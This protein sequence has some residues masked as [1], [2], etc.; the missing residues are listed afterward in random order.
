MAHEAARLA[1]VPQ[2][3]Y[4]VCGDRDLRVG[5][6]I[7]WTLGAR[8]LV[9]YRSASGRVVAMDARCPHLG[10][11]L[12]RGA[13]EGEHLRCALH[14]WTCDPAGA[15]RPPSGRGAIPQT[16]YPTAERYGS[17]FVFAGSQPRFD[18]PRL[19]DADPGAPPLRVLAGRPVLVQ[20][21]W[22]SLAM[23]A[24]DIAHMDAIHH[25]VLRE[26]PAISLIGGD[27]LELQY[28]SRITGRGIADRVVR[29]L[30]NDR[31]RATIECWG[32][33]LIVVRSRVGRIESRLLLCLTPAGGNVVVVPIVGRRSGSALADAIAL[34]IGRWLFTS[35]LARDVVPLAGMDLRI[36]RALALDGPSGWAARWLVT[37]PAFE[38]P[39][40]R[41]RASVQRSVT[42]GVSF[43]H[44]EPGRSPARQ[45][46]DAN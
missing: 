22:A 41:A 2:S 45:V 25:R 8:G 39:D 43:P 14:H 40:N 23:N 32:G 18:V 30:A 5:R 28:V 17:I 35:F 37:L 27:C 24:F 26:E 36:D 42:A 9:V 44:D 11:H 34:R 21:S 6:V 16:V 3:W 1:A 4:R 29:W 15:C 10:A 19:E 46:A 13:V 12:G 33:T 31:V 38:H 20:T 7:S